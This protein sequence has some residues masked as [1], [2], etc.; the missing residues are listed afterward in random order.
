ME[1]GN[2]A[3]GTKDIQLRENLR[4]SEKKTPPTQTL[5]LLT[6]SRFLQ[7]G[8]TNLATG[9]RFSPDHIILILSTKDNS[10]TIYYGATLHSSVKMILD[11]LTQHHNIRVPITKKQINYTDLSLSLST[12]SLFTSYGFTCRDHL[13]PLKPNASSFPLEL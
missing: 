11:V 5:H 4:E 3:A 6:M 13:F 1:P 2:E 10:Q 8:K 7:S 9:K 12:C